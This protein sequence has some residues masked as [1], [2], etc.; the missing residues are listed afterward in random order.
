MEDEKERTNRF[1][2]YL[3]AT[4]ADGLKLLFGYNSNLRVTILYSKYDKEKNKYYLELDFNENKNV[5][6]LKFDYY[7]K[8]DIN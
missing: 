1:Y 8:K 3:L 4:F 7:D 2:S 5:N 6:P